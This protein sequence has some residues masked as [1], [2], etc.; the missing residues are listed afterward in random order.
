MGSRRWCGLER[1]NHMKRYLLSAV[2]A[3]TLVGS[4][5]PSASAAGWQ[6]DQGQTQAQPMNPPQPAADQN[7]RHD[8]RRDG[9]HAWRED[10]AD[11]AWDQNQ[12][13]GYYTGSRWHY[14]A[15]PS[16]V[17][18]ASFGYH[19]WSRGQRLGYYKTRYSEVNYREHHLRR[20]NRGYHWVQDDRGDYLLAAI[21]TG[22][23]AQVIISNGR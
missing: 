19:P 11:A 12:H 15:P 17:T 14:G 10:R 18:G 13:N 22:L 21:A 4:I 5:A 16:G 9:R 20:P 8:D 3:L 6:R 7:D 1:T 23:I 2:A